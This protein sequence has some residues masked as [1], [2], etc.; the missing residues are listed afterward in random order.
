MESI[1]A[2]NAT[3]EAIARVRFEIDDEYRPDP[4][5]DWEHGVSVRPVALPSN[6]DGDYFTSDPADAFEDAW[7]RF[8]EA[9]GSVSYYSSARKTADVFTRWAGIF[10]PE[11]RIVRKSLTG[12]SQGHWADV[13]AWAVSP[14]A[15]DPADVLEEFGNYFRGDVYGLVTEELQGDE[16]A[17]DWELTESVWGVV[18]D[19]YAASEAFAILAANYPDTAAWDVEGYLS[20]PVPPAP[21]AKGGN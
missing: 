11:A 9:F 20:I 13:I 7:A 19:D 15:A 10:H 3:G 21:A 14:D 18:G 17:D 5:S 16:D 2:R 8:A 1:T 4:L 12:Y 6:S